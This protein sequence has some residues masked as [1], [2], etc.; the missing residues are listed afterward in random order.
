[1]SPAVP[2]GTEVSPAVEGLAFRLRDEAAIEDFGEGSLVLL[3]D[4]LQMREINAPSRRI[5]SHL[6]G[7]RT[8][9][10][11]AFLVAGE[12]G[13]TPG[14][15]LPEIAEA[16][17]EMERQGVVRRAAKL[18]T[19]GDQNMNN[20]KYLANP[21]VSFRQ[22]DDDG[23][24]LFN[25]DTDALEVVNPTAAAIWMFL[26]APRTRA[27]ITDHLCEV[28]EGAPRGQ[29]ETDVAEFLE[30]LLKKGFAGILE[31]RE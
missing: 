9:E 28:F 31:E 24:I 10:E 25:P 7:R 18:K 6:D 17:L 29:V 16:L 22:E 11:V 5:L 3:C 19:E 8:V 1:M 12:T 4:S 23:G 15:I 21:D 2:N 26:S 14:Q 20:A 30:S 27:D 13:T